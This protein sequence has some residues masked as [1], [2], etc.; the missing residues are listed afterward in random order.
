MLLRKAVEL[1][2]CSFLEF[3]SIY[4]LSSARVSVHRSLFIGLSSLKP[5]AVNSIQS[6]PMQYNPIQSKFPDPENQKRW[7][8]ENRE[9]RQKKEKKERET[10]QD[11]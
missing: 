2:G 6:G 4:P 11:P 8:K 3:N 5:L 10:E 7:K 9:K 1:M